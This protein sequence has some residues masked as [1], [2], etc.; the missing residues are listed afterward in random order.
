MEKRA[1][2][3][4]VL[5]ILVVFAFQA[6]LTPRNRSVSTPP[7]VQE[8]TVQSPENKG[9]TIIP[10]L[11]ADVVKPTA[12]AEPQSASS[13]TGR[14]IV[15]ENKVFKAVFSTRG[16][17]LK[18]FVLKNYFDKLGKDARPIEMVTGRQWGTYPLGVT[19]IGNESVGTQDLLFQADRESL[20]LS[21]ASE[22]DQ[23]VFSA[24]VGNGAQVRKILTFVPDRY[25]FTLDIEI[26]GSPAAS[27]YTGAAVGWVRI[28][29]LEKDTSTKLGFTG[30][31]AWA[32]NKLDEVSL[33]DLKNENKVFA[34]NVSWVG[35]EEKYFLAAFLAS[36]EADLFTAS[37]ARPTEDTVV[38]SAIE[39]KSEAES[40][41]NRIFS[42]S[43]FCGPKDIDI[44][45]ALGMHL[46]KAINFGMFDI[47]AKPLLYALKTLKEL[48]HNYGVAIIVITIILKVVFFPLTHKSYTSMKA[49]KD[50]QP[51][52]E[53][54]KKKY[55]DDRE[56]LNQETMNLYR[57]HKVNPLGGCLPLLVQF[58]IFIAFYWVL[59]GSIELRH[60]PF[61]FWIKDLSAHDPYYITPILMGAS[62]FVTQKMTP[63]SADPMQAKLMLAMPIVFTV[64]FLN[65]PSGLVIYWLVNNILQIFQQIYID[66]RVS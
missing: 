22:P 10:G 38:I 19:L 49:L 54:L 59:M 58:P 44:L 31:A 57:S 20:D 28:L 8:R 3:A 4:V 60:S 26:E 33:K 25:T 21:S 5:S 23:V 11:P 56:K 66:K 39:Q 36:S 65:F 64:M 35:Y 34:R 41:G 14:D 24:V 47:V 1:I 63:T 16:A 37:M 48:T 51:K 32:E 30:P 50:L 53:A 15:I 18:S 52:M 9:T 62:M 6:Y 43:F 40:E 61:I 17:V 45:S 42:S 2:L 27:D 12:Q 46:E 29:D 7:K 13:E 55:K